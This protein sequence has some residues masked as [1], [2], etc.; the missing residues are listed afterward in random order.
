MTSLT[1][2]CCN[3]LEHASE[4]TDLFTRN[5]K[6]E[7]ASAFERAYKRRADHGLKSWIARSE[8]RI[9]MHISVNRM[10]FHTQDRSVIGGVLGDLMVDEAHRDFWA[11]VRLVRTMVSAL[12]RENEIRFLFTTATKE[13]ETVFKAGGFKPFGQLRRYV[14]PTFKP[15][16]AFSRLRARI[17]RRVRSQSLGDDANL[18]RG[19][20]ALS[21]DFWRARVDST[22]VA[23]RI[24]RSGY[25]DGTWVILAERRGTELGCA[26]SSRHTHLPEGTL[27][28]A[29]W[30]E[31]SR[32]LSEMALAAAN[33]AGS[34]GLRTFSIT[35]LDSKVVHRDLKKAGFFPRPALG[36]LL[37]NAL[38]EMPAPADDWFLT[39]FVL[40]GW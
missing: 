15:Y 23:S 24:P 19:F 28:D 20:P 22:Y 29:L 38:H 11:P 12:K 17:P 25:L 4:I 3:P 33:H 34:R 9:V 26:L 1:I 40:S 35:M 6:P 30:T 18:P 16:V 10:E 31:R 8:G 39:G 27:A 36:D 32:G 2:E 7:F 13:A 21:G 37:V 14:I 5:G